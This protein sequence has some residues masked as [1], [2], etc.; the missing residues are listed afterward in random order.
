MISVRSNWPV[1]DGIDAEIGRKLHRA[2]HAL[3]HIDKGAVGKDRR[4]E[5]GEEIVGHRHDGAQIFLHQ[6][7]IIADRFGDRAEDHARFVQLFLE[8]GGDRNAE[9]NTASTATPASAIC[10]CSGMP[11]F[12]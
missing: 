8:G 12:L 3:G 5:R 10:S 11:S 4:I 6:L 1:S 7:G 9:S 2:A